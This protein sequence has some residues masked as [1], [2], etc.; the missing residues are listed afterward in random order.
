MDNARLNPAT[1]GSLSGKSGNFNCRLF[2]YVLN[3]EVSDTITAP[4]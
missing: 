4:S 1:S 2:N 3:V